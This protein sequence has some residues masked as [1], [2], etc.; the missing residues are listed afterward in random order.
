MLHMVYQ[1]PWILS[2]HDMTVSKQKKIDGHC[3]EMPCK[4]RHAFPLVIYR[5]M[6]SISFVFNDLF[7]AVIPYLL[8]LAMELC[9]T[10]AL[11]ASLLA[12]VPPISVFK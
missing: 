4:W 9:V 11:T 6:I 8:C 12:N 3:Q 5:L 10:A 1:R 2:L 7:V